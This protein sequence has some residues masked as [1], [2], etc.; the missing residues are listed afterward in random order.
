M[1]RYR[2][3]NVLL[4]KDELYVR[5]DFK[6]MPDGSMRLGCGDNV[7]TDTYFGALSVGKWSKYTDIDNIRLSIILSGTMRITVHHIYLKDPEVVH[8]NK[9][10][11]PK[12]KDDI[13]TEMMVRTVGKV[14]KQFDIPVFDSGLVYFTIS[15]VR[16][17]SFVFSACYITDR[18]RV[19]NV[20]LALNICTYNRFDYLKKNIELIKTELLNTSDEDPADAPVKDEELADDFDIEYLDDETDLSAGTVTSEDISDRLEVF[21]TD[22]AS[23]IDPDVFADSH[24]RVFHNRNLGG[25]GGFTKG[26]KEILKLRSRLGLTHVIFMDDD[27]FVSTESIRRTYWLLA[28]LRPE[29][30]THFIAG[31]LNRT[32]DRYIQHE[33]GALW[34]NGKCVFVGRD[35]DLRTTV[36]LLINECEYERDYAA[37]WY[38][39]MPLNIL[40]EDNLPAPLFI[41]EDDVEYS[42]RNAEGIIT[43]NGIGIWHTA[44]LHKRASV[45][46]YY[47]LRN[48]L[49]VNAIYRRRFGAMQAFRETF[50]GMASSLFRHRYADMDMSLNAALDYLKGPEFLL[51]TDAEALHASLLKKAYR[52]EYVGDA[53]EDKNTLLCT[54]EKITG[55]AKDGFKAMWRNAHGF[56]G[57]LKIVGQLLTMNGWF[58]PARRYTEAHYMNAHPAELY[59]A[60]RLILFDDADNM[61]LILDKEFGQFFKMTGKLFGVFF[62]LLFGY[63]KAARQYNERWRDLTGADYWDKVLG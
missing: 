17:E 24:I 44:T 3:H 41:H 20:H 53:I 52:F 32:E 55:P 58:L 21:I 33:N 18:E 49:I 59:R 14:R 48:M 54:D 62:K 8:S 51:N 28:F 15:D 35:L 45:N 22:N 4:N 37:W 23:N 47:N 34:N 40:G 9:A 42:L 50:N 16:K 56:G 19:A 25:A 39:C 31:S 38:C 57:R 10:D 43:M 63:R 60:G 36:N 27:A 46:L 5:G 2:F 12:V 7:S 1:N 61:G 29:Y 6:T 26:L 13:V 30:G 11:K